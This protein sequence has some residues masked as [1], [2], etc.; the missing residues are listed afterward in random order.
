LLNASIDSV[1]KTTLQLQA[2]SQEG[3]ALRLIKD[4]KCEPEQEEDAFQEK[5]LDDDESRMPDS[6]WRTES[7]VGA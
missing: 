1:M 6:G 4:G 3:Q 7:R 2:K 5:D